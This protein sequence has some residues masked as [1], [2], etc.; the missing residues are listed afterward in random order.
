MQEILYQDCKNF[1][2]LCFLLGTYQWHVDPLKFRYLL[3]TVGV[4]YIK[5]RETSRKDILKDLVEMCRGVQ[6]PLRGLFLRNYLLQCTRNLLPDLEEDARCLF[7]SFTRKIL[8][9]IVSEPIRFVREFFDYTMK[10][11]EMSVFKASIFIQIPTGNIFGKKALQFICAIVKIAILFLRAYLV[12]RRNVNCVKFSVMSRMVTWKIPLTL[13]SWISRKWTN[14]GC[15][16]NIKD[17]RATKRRGK[18]NDRN[19]VFWW[20]QILFVS[21]NLTALMLTCIRRWVFWNVQFIAVPVRIAK[22]F[23]SANDNFSIS[24]G[25]V[26]RRSWTSGE[27]QRC[28]CTGVFNGM[29]NSGKSNKY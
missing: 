22:L 10:I 12:E 2:K 14:F 6:H 23:S 20:E 7:A 19:F 28:H 24:L 21:V 25:C 5:A 1:A 27:L 13:F 3:I 26:E 4:V 8:C 17:T 9:A 18:R 29:Y 16:C 15:A 11:W